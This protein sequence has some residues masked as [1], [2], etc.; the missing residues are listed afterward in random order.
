MIEASGLSKQFGRL[1]AVDAV[2]FAIGEG[3][4][5]GFLGPNGAGK[6][7]TLRMI[8]GY[9]TPTAG[10]VHVDGIDVTTEP[11]AARSRIGYLPESVPLYTEMRVTEF[12]RFRGRLFGLSRP[13][14]QAAIESAI[15][16]CRLEDVAH[17]PIHQLSKGFRQRV[18]LA[19]TLLHDPPVLILDEPTIGLDP[20]QILEVRQLIRELG[21][22]HT[23]LLSTHILPEVEA[24]ADRV[25]MIARGRICADGTLSEL[26]SRI[27][28]QSTYL[29]E[30]NHPRAERLLRDVHHV[31]NV[32]AHE[33][34]SGWQRLEVSARTGSDDLR[35]PID[36]ALQNADGWLV[37]NLQRRQ[38]SL[39]QMFI[40]L[41]TLRN[42]SDSATHNTSNGA[43]GRAPVAEGAA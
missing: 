21:E 35:E 17:R 42:G 43:A 32:T 16:R 4:V 30:T 27:T 33:L 28:P 13:R 3:R 38:P 19:A 8:A 1:T 40:E 37:R 9:L 7:T 34:G 20:A 2:N 36:A 6:T 41:Q 22:H 5:V 12:L 23:I 15:Q 29:V 14:R 31:G 11:V 10:T 26:M 24:I 39:E 25:I 18:G